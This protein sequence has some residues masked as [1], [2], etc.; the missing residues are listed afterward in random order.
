MSDVAHE[1]QET[2]E[3]SSREYKKKNSSEKQKEDN[4]ILKKTSVSESRA[5]RTHPIASNSFRENRNFFNQCP[6]GNFNMDR[7]KLS[8]STD[9]TSSKGSKNFAGKIKDFAERH[10][11]FTKTVIKT[12]GNIVIGAIT[13]SNKSSSGGSGATSSSGRGYPDGRSSPKEHKVKEHKR[14]CG[15]KVIVVKEHQR[16]G[17][18]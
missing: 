17:N 12:V 13:N 10:P 5:D 1:Q 8:Y 18:K 6:Y 9:R 4:P 11:D 14:R 16:G 15:D 3:E 2:T 7:I